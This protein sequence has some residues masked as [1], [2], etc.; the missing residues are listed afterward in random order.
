VNV[1]A[2]IYLPGQA[3]LLVIVQIMVVTEPF[4]RGTLR[5]VLRGF[6][7]SMT[8]LNIVRGLAHSLAYLHSK[9]MIYG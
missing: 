9:C 8:K 1:P 2:L 3:E 5:H 4:E 7:H 6:V